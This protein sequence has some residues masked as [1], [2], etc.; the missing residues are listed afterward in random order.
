MI[1]LV[2][3]ALKDM[4]FRKKIMSDE[5]T[6]EYNKKWGGTIS[7]P[8]E[9]W[10]AWYDC[11]IKKSD[12]K[13]FYRYILNENHTFVGEAAYHFDENRQ[14]YLADVIVM[15]KYRGNGYGSAALNLL[16]ESAK[17]NGI[18]HLFDDI[19]ADNPAVSLFL[20]NGFCEEFRTDNYIM[21][22]RLL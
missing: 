14:I 8:E 7:F 13:R 21:L 5:Q 18:E 11:W 20:R 2:I 9:D 17:Q 12:G 1:K 19:A 16:C 10:E 15:A 3:P 4:W 22:K 6:M